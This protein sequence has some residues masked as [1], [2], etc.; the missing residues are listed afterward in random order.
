MTDLFGKPTLMAHMHAHF[1]MVSRQDAIEKFD[2]MLI[3]LDDQVSLKQ[4]AF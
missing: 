1:E 4:A 2:L 3:N